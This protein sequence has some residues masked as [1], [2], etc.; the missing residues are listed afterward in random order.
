MQFSCNFQSA[1]RYNSLTLIFEATLQ[2][3][4]LQPKF[5]NFK[6]GLEALVSA[7]ADWTKKDMVSFRSRP[8][9]EKR[10]LIARHLLFLFC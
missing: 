5:L 8:M 4:F 10:L 9:L 2:I 1:K 7:V 3:K 6:N